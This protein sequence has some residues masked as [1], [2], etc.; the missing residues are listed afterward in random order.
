AGQR[1][2]KPSDGRSDIY[3]LGVILYEMGTGHRPYSTDDPLDVVLALSHKLLRPS[4]AETH[5][6]ETV[7]DVI[8][9]MLAVDLDQ[10]YQTALEVESAL[11]AL[12]APEPVTESTSRLKRALGVAARVAAVVVVA[13]TFVTFLGFLET[14]GFNRTLGR[15]GTRFAAEPAT[16]W[17]SYGLWSLLV[18]TI[19]LILTAL[20]GWG[21]RFI[22]RVLKL[23]KGVTRLINTGVTQTNRLES[24]LNLRDPAVLGQAVSLVGIVL[25]VGIFWRH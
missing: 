10:R 13:A 14:A 25:V 4:G 8:G 19:Y 17:I 11:A 7:N 23:S 5:M 2:G 6:P 24:R 22:V 15:D 9:K 3:S 12:M 21:A 18:P 1:L 16:A 20:A